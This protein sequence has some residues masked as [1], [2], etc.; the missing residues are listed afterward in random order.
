MRKYSDQEIMNCLRNR[1]T[2]IVHYVYDTY[3]P[4]IKHMTFQMGGTK[5]DAE[6]VFQDALIIIINKTN[7]D[8]LE[9]NCQFKTYLF[10]VCENLW[11]AIRKKR[12][13]AFKNQEIISDD[14]YY[15]DFT[16]IYDSKLHNQFISGI[17]ESL[18]VDYQKI[19][20][21]TLE[22]Y[23][24]KEIAERLGYSYGYFR[25]KKSKCI[26]KLQNRINSHPAYNTIKESEILYEQLS[27][28]QE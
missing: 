10:S 25:N 27:V 23:S 5:E 28:F 26:K 11:L 22:N 4:V 18:E 12:W 8:E 19:I 15:H 20:K 9:L 21:L 1:Q 7:C 14:T 16:E 6:D 3:L 13:V 2:H 17:F 24:G